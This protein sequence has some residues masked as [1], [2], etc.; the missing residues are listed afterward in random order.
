VDP[1]AKGEGLLLIL[2][3]FT[4]ILSWPEASAEAARRA[5]ELGA[6]VLVIPFAPSAPP[7]PPGVDLVAA[8]PADAASIDAARRAG[9]RGVM[10]SAPDQEPALRALLQRYREFIRIVSLAPAQAHWNVSPAMAAVRAGHWPGLQ[11]ANGEAGAT[12]QPWINANLHVYSWLRGFFP[13]RA[14]VLDVAPPDGSLQYEGAE[15]ALAEAWAFRGGVILRLPDAMR[16]GLAR[17]DARAASSW[18]KLCETAAFLRSRAAA[19]PFV[20]AS[21]LAVLIPQWDEEFEEILNL[22]WRQ[23]LAPEVLPA[24]RFAPRAGLRF[25]AAVNHTPPAPVRQQLRDF[26][27]AGG[28]VIIAPEA[29]KPPAPWTEGARLLGKEG[30]Y[31]KCALGRGALRLFAEPVLDP[32]EFALHLREIIGMDNPLGRGLHGLDVRIWNAATVLPVLSRHAGGVRVVLIA[33]GRRLDHDFLVGLRGRWRRAELVQPGAAA[34]HLK[35]MQR[36]GRVEWNQ[37]GLPRLAV[38][39]LEEDAR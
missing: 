1:S 28:T 37:P 11:A 12:E 24:G 14:P 26:A 21:S 27:A 2:A 39:T 36:A 29:G 33:Y 20:S 9:F 23:Q 7:A 34:A 32:Y 8:V 18:S 10:I 4:V 3:A 6:G 30:P 25:A 19:S 35:L 5:G 16:E 22:A 15:I 17:G 31:E 38:V 13:G